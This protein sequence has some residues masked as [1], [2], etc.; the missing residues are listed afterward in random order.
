VTRSLAAVLCLLATLPFGGCRLHVLRM[1]LERPLSAETYDAIDVG[2]ADRTAILAQLGPP[3]RILYT[4]TE[5]VLDYRSASHRS[6]DLLFYLPTDVL[7][8]LRIV[9]PTGVLRFFFDPFV[10]PEALREPSLVQ[11]GR[12]SAEAATSLIPFASGIDLLVLRSRQLRADEIRVVL[13]RD[14]H[15]VQ[16]KALRLATGEYAEQTLSESAGL[17]TD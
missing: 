1:D 3:D 6:T 16:R 13:D 10:E 17:R 9:V 4:R 2:V 11:L 12:R 14:T 5:E 15:A 8:G 7:G